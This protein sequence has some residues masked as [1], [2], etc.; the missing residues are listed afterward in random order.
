[1][2]PSRIGPTALCVLTGAMLLSTA[3]PVSAQ[4]LLKDAG[5][6]LKRGASDVLHVWT[7]PAHMQKRDLH[8]LAVVAGVGGMLLLTDGQIQDWVD[9][10]PSSAVVGALRPF[11]EE[12]PL[13]EI[14]DIWY[15]FRYSAAAWVVGLAVDSETMREAAMGCM[16]A[17]V[18]QAVPRRYVLYESIARTRPRFTDDPYEFA[19]PGENEWSR[20]SFPGGHAANAFTCI[21]YLGNR[22]EL[23]VF[24][25][26][27]YAAATG[28]A[29][30]RVP[31]GAHWAS[32][33]W[34]GIALGYAVGRAVALH[35]SDDEDDAAAPAPSDRL[36]P[37]EL[38]LDGLTLGWTPDGLQLRYTRRF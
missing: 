5:S 8:G 12:Q 28:A 9:D 26:L 7:A 1:M 4:R 38:A 37:A 34:L 25:P 35:A 11:R 36:S 22:Y 33:S 20:R 16:A 24:E 3:A 19:V 27:L 13:E 6:D 30:A 17:G 14:G 2:R 18:A 32:D 10:N 21:S 29:L 23:G 31:D 15:T